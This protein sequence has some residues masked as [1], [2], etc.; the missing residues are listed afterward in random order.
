MTRLT[1]FCF[2]SD[3]IDGG[4]AHG[5]TPSAVSVALELSRSRDYAQL[6]RMYA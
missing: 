6:T 5:S 3:C 4:N 2:D 1:R